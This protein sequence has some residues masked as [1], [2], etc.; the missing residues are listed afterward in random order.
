[1]AVPRSL[2]VVDVGSNTTNVAVF[3]ADPS[4]GA[5]DRVLD[6][7]E[8]LRLF[9]R[10]GPDG[11][12]PPAVLD[13]TVETI[14]RLVAD[15]RAHGADEVDVVATSAVRDARNGQDLV[16]RVAGEPGVRVRILDGRDEGVCAAVCATN[17][18]PVE[19]G[20]VVDLGGG[21]LQIVEVR[22]RRPA[23]AASLPLGALRLTD[24][25]RTDGV[26]APDAI[27][28]LRRHVEGQLR[29]VP[30]FRARGTLV[31]VGGTIRA[32]AKMD[33]RGKGW[34]VSHGHGYRLDRDAVES[35]WERVSRLDPARRKD[36]PGLSA[37][38]VDLIVAGA[39]VVAWSLRASGFEELLTSSY[40]VREGVALQRLYGVEQPVVPDVREA[41]LAGRF[42]GAR[43]VDE[44]RGRQRAAEALFDA[45]AGALGL[46]RAHRGPFGAA[47]RILAAAPTGGAP[48]A[49][50]TLLV[51][52]L[53]GF[54]QEETVR[55][56]DLLLPAPRHALDAP[57]HAGLRVLLDVAAIAG[58]ARAVAL[59]GGTVRV[60]GQVPGALAARFRAAFGRDLASAGA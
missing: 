19:E 10:L 22:E 3:R 15:A 13:R 52:P 2:A 27:N 38:R 29:T 49:A 53:Q 30:W 36:I 33:R 37:H 28:A 44:A 45:L 42:V 17:T 59:E 9:R 40:G 4:T 16:D 46:D 57:T 48:A 1:M 31:G 54:V 47:A 5:L 60:S 56:V 58:A 8:P 12:L 20:F 23:R 35:A 6:E 39:G 50:A 7:S 41:G 34:P 24:T 51:A 21:S 25:F 32:I 43:P 26:P 14:L 11:G 55:I 18:L